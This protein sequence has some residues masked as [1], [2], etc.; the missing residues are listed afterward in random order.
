VRPASHNVT[1]PASGSSRTI[2]D[3]YPRPGPSLGPF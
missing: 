2:F 3:L 1:P